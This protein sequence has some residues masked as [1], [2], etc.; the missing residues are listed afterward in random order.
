[1]KKPNM[2]GKLVDRE[3]EDVFRLDIEK[4]NVSYGDII[5]EQVEVE[6]LFRKRKDSF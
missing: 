2:T 5:C 3:M 1:M 4:L 6:H